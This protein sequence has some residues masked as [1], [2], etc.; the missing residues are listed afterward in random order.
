MYPLQKKRDFHNISC[1]IQEQKYL[2]IGI[3]GQKLL[4]KNK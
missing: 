3:N 1:E 4:L 2:V